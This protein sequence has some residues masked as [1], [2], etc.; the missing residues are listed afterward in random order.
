M[1]DIDKLVKHSRNRTPN[2]ID[3]ISDTYEF[4]PHFRNGQ[5]EKIVVIHRPGHGYTTIAHI[6]GKQ[7]RE[8][9]YPEGQWELAKSDLEETL[10]QHQC[11]IFTIK[12][13]RQP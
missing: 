5:V 1:Y 6:K 7:P 2:G 13:P 8:Q 12:D 3:P 9:N 10:R 11:D 4:E